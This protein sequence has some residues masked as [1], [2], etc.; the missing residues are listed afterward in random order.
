MNFREAFTYKFGRAPTAEDVLEFETNL[1]LLNT[2][3]DDAML[4]VMLLLK[5]D[6]EQFSKIPA[7]IDSA[8]E[9]AEK[10]VDD[11]AQKSFERAKSNLE[12]DMQRAATKA[13]GNLTDVA[14][15]VVIN[16][17]KT[18]SAVDKENAKAHVIRE[19]T[20]LMRHY[21]GIGAA[22]VLA[23]LLGGAGIMYGATSA[24]LYS[25]KQDVQAAVERAVSAENG[26]TAA[27]EA[28]VSAAT[29]KLS[30]ELETLRA[31]TAWA[32]TKEGIL[33]SSCNV[34][35]W[36]IESYTDGTKMC[37][38]NE[39]VKS[40]MGKDTPQTGFWITGNATKAKKK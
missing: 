36:R 33:V 27:A 15:E 24:K 18:I 4:A 21:A 1:R 20:V 35:G 39:A 6:R 13:L 37:I 31:S 29:Q 3:P 5:H 10:R 9:K 19:Q 34:Q 30:N 2:T 23:S 22:L 26:S 16:A 38:T 14:K 17:G 12:V 40:F 32:A 25:A 28:A 7:A 8:A 11:G